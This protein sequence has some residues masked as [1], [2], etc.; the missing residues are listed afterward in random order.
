MKK[1][2]GQILVDHNAELLNLEDDIT[3]Y[4]KKFESDILKNIHETAQKAKD[5]ILYKNRDFY[6]VVLSK[7]EKL[8]GIPRTFTFARRS[9]PTPLYNQSVWKY[10]NLIGDLEYLWS[11]PDFILYQHILSH[12]DKYISDRECSQLA[13]FV[14][15]MESG[16]LL[17]W[18]KRENG[19]KKDAVIKIDKENACQ[20]N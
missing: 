14:L 6:I 3:E 16:E 1:T 11:I 17:E 2:Y 9:C 4:R 18:V 20:T 8:G 19:E 13:K 5:D 15:L 10:R 12:S 7:L